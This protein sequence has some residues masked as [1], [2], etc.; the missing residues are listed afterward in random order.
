MIGR[1]GLLRDALVD[2]GQVAEGVPTS[3]A[4]ALLARTYGVEMPVFAAVEAVIRGRI[5]PSQ[6]VAMLM[7]RAPKMDDFIGT[8]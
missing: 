4:A 8:L 7:D 2:L 5:P 6:A 1:G 3:E